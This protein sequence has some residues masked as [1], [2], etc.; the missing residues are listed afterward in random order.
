MDL[1]KQRQLDLKWVHEKAE[2][3]G[4]K[5]D[6]VQIFVSRQDPTTDTTISVNA[7]TGNWHARRGQVREWLLKQDEFSRLAA[8]EE[9]EEADEEEE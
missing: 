9:A 4:A 6:S 2:E 7:G 8:I 1:E 3:L 5:F